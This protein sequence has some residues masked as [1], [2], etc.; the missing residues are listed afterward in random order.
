M[1]WLDL[2]F[3]PAALTLLATAAA[4][5]LVALFHLLENSYHLDAARWTGLI[6]DAYNFAEKEGVFQNLDSNGKLGAALSRFKDQFIKVYTNQPTTQDIA[7]ATLDLAKLAF[8]SKF[9]PA[10][11]P[12]TS[13][14]TINTNT[15]VQTK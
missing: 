14:A 12:Q 8:Q 2:I 11:T 4:Y 7:D 15:A 6:A 9:A 13:T 10:P 5:G 1:S 3:S